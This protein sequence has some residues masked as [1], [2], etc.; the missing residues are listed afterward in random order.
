MDSYKKLFNNTIIFTIGN[1]GSKLIAFILVPLYTHY[2]TQV[3]YGTADLT[4]TTISML[5][6]VVSL[7]M[8]ESVIRFVMHKTY[9]QNVIMTNTLSISLIGYGLFLLFYPILKFFNVFVNSLEYMYI[10]LLLQIFNQIF[11]QYTRGIGESKKFALNGIITTFVSGILNIL[12]LVVFDWG[13]NGYFLAFIIA[14]FLSTIYLLLVTRPIRG[15]KFELL[16]RERISMLL[17]YSLPLIPHNLMWWL[18]NSSSRY[19]INWFVGIEANGIFAVSSKIPALINIISQVFSQAWQISAFEKYD[20]SKDSEFYANVFD[21]YMS[22]LLIATSAILLVLK[23]MLTILFA[24]SY[25][26]AWQPV[27]F[28]M[29]GS[30]FSAAS[31]FVGVV[32]TASEKTTGIFKTSIY[33][34]AVSIILNLML[35]PFLGIVGAGI[36]SAISFFVMFVVR[37]ID[38]KKILYFKIESKK[39]TF[40]IVL[41]LAQTVILFG[42]FRQSVEL[43]MNG[44][45]FI[46]LLIINQKLLKSS[47]MLLKKVLKIN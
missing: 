29:L 42:G 6:P 31:V 45:L 21:L 46:Y 44:I 7:T 18:V 22:M 32:Y 3:E 11:A 36:S 20:N 13:L 15:L 35:I 5:I 14:Y 4:M 38:A 23:P 9:D 40:T 33:G 25:L 1:L 41:I 47:L 39:I 2:L 26:N 19:F 34:G 43:T 27:P 24:E 16:S 8:H 17:N 30:I 10:L 37:Y 12:F 28:L